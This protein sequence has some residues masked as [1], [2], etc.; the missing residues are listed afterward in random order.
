MQLANDSRTT[1][2]FRLEHMIIAHRIQRNYWQSIYTV[3][4]EGEPIATG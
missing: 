2:V 4:T 3:T 1:V